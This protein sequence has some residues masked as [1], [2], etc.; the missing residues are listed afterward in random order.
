[1]APETLLKPENIERLDGVQLSL[2]AI[3]EAHCLSQWG[4]DFRPEYRALDCLVR[5]SSPR[6]AHRADS[7]G[8]CADEG[9]NR[10]ASEYRRRRTASSP[11]STVPTSATRRRK[12]RARCSR[13][14]ASS[15]PT[16]ARAASSIACPNARRTR[17]RLALNARG[18]TALPYHAGMDDESAGGQPA[19]L[20]ASSKG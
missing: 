4:H 9:G 6:A 10:R 16:R 11:A 7:H 12:G 13:C 3:D 5:T 17:R 14:S 19:P 20:P 8:G 2:I 18:F 15:N 1:M